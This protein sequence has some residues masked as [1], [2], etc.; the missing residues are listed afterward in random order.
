MA[1]K[2]FLAIDMGA[3]SGRHVAGYFDGGKLRLQELYR[4]EN[5]PI[6]AAGHLYWDMLQQWSHVKNGLRAAANQASAPIA[7]VGVDTWGVDFALLGRNDELLANPFCYRDGQTAEM[8]DRAFR[9]VPR[10]EVFAHTGVQFMQ[11]NTLYHLLAMRLRGAPVLDVAEQ[12]L[13]MPDLFHFLLSGEKAIEFTDATTTQCFDPN[14]RTWATALLER[15]GIPTHIFKPTSLPGT[16]LGPLRAAVTEETGLANCQVVLPGSHDTASAVLAVPFTGAISDKPNWCYISSGTW[17]LV[18]VEVPQPV[19]GEKCLELNFTN[20]GGVGNTIRLLKN[21]GGLWL[22]Q[23]CRRVWNLAGKNYNWDDL[24]R[25][26]ANAKPLGS[27]INPDHRD[28]LAPANMPDA[29]RAYCQR[30]GQP[31]PA[32]EGAV[33]RTCLDSLALRYRQV[34]NWLEELTGGKIETIHI[35]GGGTQNKL[36]NQATAD[37]C[38]RRVI[39]GPIEATAAGNVL[40]QA[41]AAG[42]IADIS[43]AR[44]VVAR[45]FEVQTYEPRDTAQW[46]DAFGRFEKL[47]G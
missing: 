10:E 19:L 33:L 32:D 30:T 24:N 34:I 11:I 25:L 44:Q 38:G 39:T 41:M 8:M 7:S 21:V 47:P 26:T 1:E 31:A 6:S 46:D 29:I 42:E 2:A 4:F 37:A 36:L 20:E 22:L 35:V 9:T 28:F 5:G 27:L 45:S 3:S 14:S 43:Q 18:G 17:S 13:M 15:L 12:F 23:E 40:V 16:T